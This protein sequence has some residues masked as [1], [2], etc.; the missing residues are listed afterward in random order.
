MKPDN[1][2]T[3]VLLFKRNLFDPGGQKKFFFSLKKLTEKL[4]FND[5]K[6]ALKRRND[7]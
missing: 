4:L 2:K 3:R 1:V 5:S 7:I 6:I